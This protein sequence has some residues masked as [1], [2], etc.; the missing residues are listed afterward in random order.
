MDTEIPFLLLLPQTV[1][2]S[3][4]R[5]PP[6]SLICGLQPLCI[7]IPHWMGLTCVAR[8]YYGYADV[9]LPGLGPKKHWDFCLALPRVPQSGGSQLPC[10]GDTPAFC[11]LRSLWG[12]EPNPPTAFSRM[13]ESHWSPGPS[14]TFRGLHPHVAYRPV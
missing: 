3:L 9:Y 10:H 1:M 7:P 2:T 13:S 5:W 6:G 8:R 11:W 12:E 4:K 14:Q